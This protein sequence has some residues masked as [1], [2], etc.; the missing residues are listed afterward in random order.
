MALCGRPDACQA[1]SDADQSASFDYLPEGVL[2]Q[3]LSFLDLEER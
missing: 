3:V 1:I 2:V